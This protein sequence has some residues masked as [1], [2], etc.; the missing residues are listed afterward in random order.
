[1]IFGAVYFVELG[2]TIHS[3]SVTQHYW[4]ITAAG[5]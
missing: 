4:V 5:T 1:M 3:F 2:A